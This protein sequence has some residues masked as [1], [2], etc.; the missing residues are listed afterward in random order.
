MGP[1]V[2]NSVSHCAASFF[3]YGS[4]FT[5]KNQIKIIISDHSCHLV[6]W[7]ILV[8]LIVLILW[9]CN[10][11]QIFSFVLLKGDKGFMR[12]ARDFVLIFLSLSPGD[13]FSFKE[14][15][16]HFTK[17]E[18]WIPLISGTISKILKGLMEWLICVN[19]SSKAWLFASKKWE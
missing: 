18:N 12:R 10:K 17:K 15:D 1:F 6:N 19:G 9:V 11:S 13:T 8:G 16:H 4:T 5:C 14:L 7:R 3:M 2:W